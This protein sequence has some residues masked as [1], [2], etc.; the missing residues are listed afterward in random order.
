MAKPK[1]AQ[2]KSADQDTDK[3]KEKEALYGAS[4]VPTTPVAHAA[5]LEIVL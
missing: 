2:H 5:S 3:H 4:Y 1:K